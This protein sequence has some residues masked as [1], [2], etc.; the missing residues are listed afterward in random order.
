MVVFCVPL[1]AAA[2][3]VLP[4]WTDSINVRSCAA[5]ASARHQG[6]FLQLFGQGGF[7]GDGTVLCV[8]CGAYA[9]AGFPATGKHGLRAV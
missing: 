6:R 7:L 8:S 5:S 2:V 4:R 1:A 9:S 3:P